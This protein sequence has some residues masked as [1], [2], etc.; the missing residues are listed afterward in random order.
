MQESKKIGPHI[1]TKEELDALYRNKQA[2]T[3]THEEYKDLSDKDIE[4]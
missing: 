2:V 3:N 4:I 1:T